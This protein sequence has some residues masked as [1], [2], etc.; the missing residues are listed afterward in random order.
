[1]ASLR[2]KK[3][4]KCGCASSAPRWTKATSWAFDS[5]QFAFTNVLSTF[6]VLL[7]FEVPSFRAAD[8]T[9]HVLCLLPTRWWCS[10]HVT[11]NSFP[12]C[13]ILLPWAS[14]PDYFAPVRFTDLCE[15]KA[16]KLLC[17]PCL[18]P[19]LH[20]ARSGSKPKRQHAILMI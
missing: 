17:S 4:V 1:M 15:L 18:K 19:C 9:K 16:S 7:A 8:A 3:A 6:I 5:L 2:F 11:E 10:F 13:C 20:C 12:A 14:S